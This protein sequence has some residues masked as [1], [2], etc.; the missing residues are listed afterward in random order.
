M[1][2]LAAGARSPITKNSGSRSWCGRYR[3]TYLAGSPEITTTPANRSGWASAQVPG[4]VAPDELAGGEDPVAV[5]RVALAGVAQR[6]LD[7]GVLAGG[8]VIIRRL[9]RHGVFRRDQD[10]APASR[11][12]G[13]L[14]DRRVGP[15]P[16]CSTTTAG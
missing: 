14:V 16:E 12:G 8:V 10:I 5:D 4:H 1:N 6:Q 7:G 13:P 3:G 11:L 15:W 2:S 9:A